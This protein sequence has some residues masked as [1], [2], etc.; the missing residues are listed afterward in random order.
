MIPFVLEHGNVTKQEAE[1]WA[2]ELRERGQNGNYYKLI[3]TLK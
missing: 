3:G 2:V 1:S